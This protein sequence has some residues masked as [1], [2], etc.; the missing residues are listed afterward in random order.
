VNKVIKASKT[1]KRSIE[2]RTLDRC[3]APTGSASS[4][5]CCAIFCFRQPDYVEGWEPGA[6]IDFDPH[7]RRTSS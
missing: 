1:G 4:I 6:Y 7:L 5:V 3:S 2:N